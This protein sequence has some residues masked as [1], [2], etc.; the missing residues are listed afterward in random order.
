MLNIDPTV[1][2]KFKNF[3]NN[4]KKTHNNTNRIYNL[5]TYLKYFQLMCNYDR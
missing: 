2:K 1:F 3:E 5:Y 4:L